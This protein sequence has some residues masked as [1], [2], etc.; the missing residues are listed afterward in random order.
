[1]YHVSCIMVVGVERTRLVGL[2]KWRFVRS[3]THQIFPNHGGGRTNKNRN[4]RRIQWVDSSSP[5]GIID[6]KRGKTLSTRRREQ[7]E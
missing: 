2:K 7:S 3:A 1:M 6:D 4:T 5:S